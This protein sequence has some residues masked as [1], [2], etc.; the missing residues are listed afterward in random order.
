MT[1]ERAAIGALVCLV[2][3]CSQD[4]AAPSDPGGVHPTG[5]DDPTSP[6]WHGTLLASEHWSGML[7]P[8]ANDA[9]GRCHAG[10]PAPVP[11]VTSFAPGATACT[12]C[13]SEPSGPLAC[14]TCHSPG[15]PHAAHI[16]PS[17]SDATGLPCST[18]HPVPGEPVIGGLHGD[19]V[20]EV[21]FDPA[22]VAP[23]ASYDGATRVCAVACHDLGGAR[24]RPSWNDTKPIVC[25]D[26][27]TSP[28][29]GHFPGPC[30]ECHEEANA[31]GTALSGGPLHM[32]GRVDLG[33]GNGTCSACHGSGEDPWPTT[34]AHRAHETSSL[35]LPVACEDC[36][37]VPAAV[38]SPGHLDGVAQIAFSG[39]AVARGSNATWDGQRCSSVACHG[40]NLVDAPA[41]VPAWG[42]TS[43]AAGACG[44]CHGIPPTEHTPSTSCGRSTCHGAEVTESATGLLSIS[45]GGLSLHIDGVID[46]TP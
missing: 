7:D 29:T 28:P 45:D 32:N 40:A 11:G 44:A 4:R 24:P 13:H 39:L 15:G 1:R 36:H 38:L 14:D 43:G 20:V 19:G 6:A 25:G 30:T 33:N 31:S 2:A 27:H 3:A 12:T 41:V 23:E 8:N 42:D 18:C 5:I 9:C 34:G 16:A 17:P 10:S 22:R 35:S 26:C 21:V 46:P 37:V